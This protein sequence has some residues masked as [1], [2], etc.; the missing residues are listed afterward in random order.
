MDYDMILPVIAGASGVFAGSA[1]LYSKIRQRFPVKVNCWFCNND[2]KVEFRYQEGWICPSCQQYNGFNEEG[3]YNRDIP[4]QYCES[5]NTPLAQQREK[6]PS[7]QTSLAHGNGLC[8]T[9]NLNQTLKIRALADYTPIHPDNYDKE[10]EDYRKRLERTYALCRECEATLHQTLGKQDS[11]LK[12]WLISWR[13]YLTSENKTRLF[14]NSTGGQQ[15]NLFYLHLLHVMGIVISLSLFLCNLHHLQQHSGVQLVSLNFGVD[16]EVY[17]G[18]LHKYSSPLIVAGLSLLLVSICS[19]GKEALQ[20]TDAVASFV[21]VGLLALCSSK[22]LIPANDYNS[23]Q[24]LVSGAAVLFTV[25]T[26]F[27]RRNFGSTKI[28]KTTLGNKSMMSEN[29]S[30]SL[31][32]SRCTMNTSLG[33]DLGNLNQPFSPSL[34][35]GKTSPVNLIP[36]YPSLADSLDT[37]LSSLKISTPLK[38][39]LRIRTNTPFSPKLLFTEKPGYNPKLNDSYCSQRSE[40]SPSRFSA[41]NITQSSWVAGGYWGHPVSPSREFSQ[42]VMPPLGPVCPGQSTLYPLSRSSSQSSGFVSQSSGLPPYNP[43]AVHQLHQPY[44]LPNSCHGSHYGELDR[45][46]VLSEPAYKTWGY[47][48][49]LY[50]SD[51]ASQISYGHCRRRV[52]GDARSLYSSTSHVSDGSLQRNPPSPPA[53][54]SHFYH[55]AHGNLSEN[56]SNTSSSR[57]TTKVQA[58]DATIMELTNRQANHCKSLNYRNPWIAFFLGMSIAANGFLVVVLYMHEDIKS[59]LTS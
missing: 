44:S 8:H 5:L 16:L 33:D 49:S 17:L 18:S 12:P 2:T 32:D 4:A 31:E 42:N 28:R 7:S 3:D 14:S 51:S 55:S 10:I 38:N 53:S 57:N 11:W 36:E 48:P 9:C 22:R 46:S 56:S 23:L 30:G 26:S 25:L 41:K 37:T 47:S 40:T 35:N 29:S 43:T 54:S 15:R 20:I 1:V 59:F 13:L 6:K 39:D 58:P 27:V 45:G 34:N 24:V 52:A 19:F 21:W 50:P